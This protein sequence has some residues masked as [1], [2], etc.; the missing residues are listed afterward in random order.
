MAC[1]LL[2]PAYLAL[3]SLSYNSSHHTLSQ[4]TGSN[5]VGCDVAEGQGCLHPTAL[6]SSL[7]L[8]GP[9]QHLSKVN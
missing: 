8:T 4:R 6:Q 5:S 9:R 2:L 7:S 1:L 3:I